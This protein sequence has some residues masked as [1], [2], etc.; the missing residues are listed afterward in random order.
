M[1]G[2][3]GGQEVAELGA[4]WRPRSA[5]GSGHPA[6]AARPGRRPG[7]A[8]LNTPD[9]GTLR[10][11]PAAVARVVLRNKVTAAA[12]RAS[13]ETGFFARLRGA[14]MLVRVRY[15]QIDPGQVTGAAEGGRAIFVE[16]SVMVREPFRLSP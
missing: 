4:P 13:D 8:K 1:I 9:R 3:T 7:A 2:G 11:M 16:L 10:A 12:E 14:A 6:A 5:P 15:S